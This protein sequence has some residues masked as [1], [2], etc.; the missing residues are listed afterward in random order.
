LHFLQKSYKIYSEEQMTIQFQFDRE[1][2]IQAIS[3][4]LAELS[5]TTKIPVLKLLFLAD[6]DHLKKHGRPISGDHPYAMRLGPVL[7]D[8]Y[9]LICHRH[10]NS[11]TQEMFDKCISVRGQNV[12]LKKSAGSDCLSE[13]DKQSLRSILKKFGS[14]SARQLSD[15]THN[16]TCY[17]RAFG[18]SD[19]DSSIR[20]KWEDVL[21]D[22]PKE[23]RAMVED[24]QN[25]MLG[26][27][28]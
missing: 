9:D 15:Y 5:S 28:D 8:T 24:G 17:V 20:M 26:F 7:S 23:V 21:E 13:T 14:W 3:F 1:K 10:G 4:I 11:K 25:I 22:A 18:D 2:A 19:D 6:V 12:S 27:S 16:L